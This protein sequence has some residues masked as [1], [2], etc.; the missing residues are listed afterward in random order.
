[1]PD[2]S[3]ST[4]PALEPEAQA[5][6]EA[7]GGA[8]AVEVSFLETL[9]EWMS[10]PVHRTR[11]GHSLVAARHRPTTHKPACGV[12]HHRRRPRHRGPARLP[13]QLTGRALS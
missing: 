12:G 13:G 4:G 5:F 1:M 8:R 6:A 9:A 11:T 10:R 2:D 3:T 7:T